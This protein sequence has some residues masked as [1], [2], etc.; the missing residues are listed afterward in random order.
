MM[1]MFSHRF[2]GGL[3][4]AALEGLEIG[5]SRSFGASCH[6][7]CL[8]LGLRAGGVDTEIPDVRVDAFVGH[9]YES[10]FAGF[11]A[12][13]DGVAEDAAGGRPCLKIQV[14]G[15]VG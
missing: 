8:L 1:R 2:L 12:L 5:K 9:L 13:A 10:V 3:R 6:G 11:E 15:V 14:G 4:S 7:D